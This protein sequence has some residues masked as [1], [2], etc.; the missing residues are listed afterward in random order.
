[1]SSYYDVKMKSL[2]KKKGL[3]F[4][5][6]AGLNTAGADVGPLDSSCDYNFYPLQVG[7]E[8]T[9]GFADDFRTGSTLTSDHTAS[10]VFDA[11]NGRFGTNSARFT[12]SS[13][14]FL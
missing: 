12:H 6:L 7:K 4:H 14:A 10:F 13:F 2:K 3:S 1:M 11:R 8:S 5:N 9:H